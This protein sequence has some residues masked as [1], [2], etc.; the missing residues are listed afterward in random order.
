MLP[1]VVA[2]GIH[3]SAA[4]T[5]V[6]ALGV[7]AHLWFGVQTSVQTSVTRIL[8]THFSSTCNDYDTLYCQT[9]VEIQYSYNATTTRL[10]DRTGQEGAGQDKTGQER[11][12]A[13]EALKGVSGRVSKERRRHRPSKRLGLVCVGHGHG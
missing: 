10:Q 8:H 7:P 4:R 9:E 12:A 3:Q 11:A 6:F 5:V 13:A 1:L 2:Q